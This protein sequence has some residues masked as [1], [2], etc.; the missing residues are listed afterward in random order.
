MTIK[1][2]SIA[3]ARDAMT[4]GCAGASR[5]AVP[6]LVLVLGAACRDVTVP[7]YNNP[8]VNSLTSTPTA[9]VVNTAVLGML[10]QYRG[11]VN[12]ETWQMGSF[13][14]EAY[15]LL[16]AEPRDL[17]GF[18]AG[19]IVPGGFAQDIGWTSSY[20]N[21]R[22]AQVILVAVDKVGAYTAQQ[23]ESV[24]GFV[25][26]IAAMEL[27]R[28]IKVR[29]TLGIVVDVGDNPDVLGAVLGKDAVLARVA[30][31]LD[32]AATHLLA[33]GAAFP[34]TLTSG[35][36][37]FNTPPTFLLVNRGIKTRVDLYQRHWQQALT[38]V[39]A[40]FIDVSSPSLTTLSKGAYN[41]WSS[42]SGDT[43][44]PL[45]DPTP[46][47]LYVHPSIV[48]GAQKRADGTPDLRLTR[49]TAAGNVRTLQGVQGTTKFVIYASQSDPTP[50]IKNE[51]LILMRAEAEFQLGNTA[52]AVADLNV[53]RVAS[54]G[55]APLA[56]DF[57]GDFITE[58]LYNRT[59]SLLLEQGTRWIDARRYGRLAQLP[60]TSGGTFTEQIFPYVMFPDAECTQRGLSS[61]A[62]ACSQVPGM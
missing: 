48:S 33:G 56:A 34:F 14:R 18:Y 35:F 7:N 2:I 30:A 49:K 5:L 21:L 37:G 62:A 17:L 6:A 8:S 46:T 39:N 31:L 16:Q 54:G 11:G 28:Q 59:Y 38:D 41:V 52:A 27:L 53:V 43:P 13:G 9:S 1:R 61:T 47:A 10:V 4:G 26:T 3:L 29:D 42:A 12:A 20:T 19:P 57:S 22:A 24:K 36:A 45:F 32:S 51:E 58:L 55:L 40:S 44:N 25:Q 60:K 23:K 15:N 50:I